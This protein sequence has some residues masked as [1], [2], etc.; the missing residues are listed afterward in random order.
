MHRHKNIPTFY[1]Y[2]SALTIT[3]SY[4]ATTNKMYHKTAITVINSFDYKT[5]MLLAI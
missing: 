2:T 4:N 1:M 3:A 5:V